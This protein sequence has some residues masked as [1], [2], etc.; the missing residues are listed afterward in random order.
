M[1]KIANRTEIKLISKDSEIFSI[2]IWK[3]D[4]RV[5]KFK[6]FDLNKYKKL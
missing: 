3:L 6:S 4:K 2:K 1:T 5:N